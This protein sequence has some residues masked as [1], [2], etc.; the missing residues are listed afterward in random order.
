VP[1]LARQPYQPIEVT[2][3]LRP[4]AE[5]IDTF[6]RAPEPP[7]DDTLSELARGLSVLDRNL[8]GFVEKRNAEGREEDAIK[9]EAEFHRN[10]SVGYAEAVSKGLIP[11]FAS[12]A[13]VSGWKQSEGRTAGI[14]L[15]HRFNDAYDKWEGKTSDDPEAL[16]K[17]LGGFLQE[18][19][20]T[21]DPE[22]LR[23]LLPQ[24]QKLTR[25]ANARNIQ[26]R[27]DAT[28]ARSV[29]AHSALADNTIDEVARAG[30][31]AE[32]GPDYPRM[33]D[34]ITTVRETAIQSGMP[35]ERI[36]PKIIDVVA[37]KAIE[38][39]E[40]RI[41]DYLNQ[42]VPG[43]QHSWGDTPYG[44]SVKAQTIDTLETMGRK[45]IAEE[46]RLQKEADR[47]G[48][49]DVTARTV[50]A[51]IANP[52]GP[53]PEK[54][55]AE[56]QRYDPEFK[57]NAM[58]WQES[59]YRNKGAAD[60]QALTDI[61]SRIIN[62]EGMRAVRWGMENGHLANREDLTAAF[63]LVQDM[64]NNGQLVDTA[65][66]GGTAQAILGS[67]KQRTLSSDDATALFAPDGLS[68]AGLAASYDFKRAVLDW[69]SRN[70][71][72]DAREQE[73]VIA[74]IGAGILRRI[75][76]A[77][78]GFGKETYSREGLGAA[79]PFAPARGQP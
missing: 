71:K 47:K 43:T 2:E 28:M 9:G 41:L 18:N 40:P 59:V 38:L 3:R 42:N 78:D 13:F 44:R 10:N 26:D 6:V 17:F 63:K 65:L 25:R 37:A 52:G 73:A 39:R 68:D 72:A 12:K 69:V 61:F 8:A 36:D 58:K 54:L 34:A 50:E 55:L 20:K 62:G 67:I 53:L 57:L 74:E 27:H 66:K 4:Q 56:G 70:P 22:V 15:G 31:A 14:N 35:A 45:A 79:N 11:A 24:V 51:I 46:A 75:G 60:P 33:F 29:N 16:P 5:A 76:R 48:K 19:I 32:N 1:S 77:D 7:K 21:Q 23:G 30:K 49:D 64:D